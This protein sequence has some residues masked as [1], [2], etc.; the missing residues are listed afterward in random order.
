[1]LCTTETGSIHIEEAVGVARGRGNVEVQTRM[2]ST[3]LSKGVSRRKSSRKFSSSDKII[4]A[5]LGKKKPKPKQKQK[6]ANNKTYEH[7]QKTNPNHES[8]EKRKTWAAADPA[9]EIYT[10]YVVALEIKPHTKRPG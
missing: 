6:V 8:K 3:L 2:N 7:P 4:F 1:M 5:S 9:W 10:G